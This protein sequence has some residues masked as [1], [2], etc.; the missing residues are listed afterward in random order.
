MLRIVVSP[1]DGGTLPAYHTAR[2][3]WEADPRQ[4]MM[5]NWMW[6]AQRD[7]VPLL[8]NAERPPLSVEP[9]PHRS[10]V[11]SLAPKPRDRYEPSWQEATLLSGRES[12]ELVEVVY[13]PR[14]AEYLI[15]RLQLVQFR[16]KSPGHTMPR[17]A[18]DWVAWKVV[19][20]G[21]ARL[22]VTPAGVVAEGLS[23][24]EDPTA[25][26]MKVMLPKAHFSYEERLAV[27]GERLT[28]VE[29]ICD[30][31]AEWRRH[32]LNDPQSF[33]VTI[34]D[35]EGTLLREAVIVFRPAVYFAP[36]FR[37]GL[38]AERNCERSPGHVHLSAVTIENR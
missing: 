11:L 38:F 20:A 32:I 17:R 3:R 2:V 10:S 5:S 30:L 37:F 28:E 9:W 8:A 25:F 18:F 33:R 35:R 21:A 36:G 16:E 22:R 12:Q 6:A 13:V 26:A 31:Y 34:I 1:R 7:Y 23:P 29:D 4:P 14:G 27:I 19:A 15:L 24:G